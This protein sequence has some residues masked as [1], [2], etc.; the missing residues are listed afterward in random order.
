MLAFTLAGAGQGTSDGVGWHDGADAQEVSGGQAHRRARGS[1]KFA[2]DA[3]SRKSAPQGG[4]ARNPEGTPHGP[5]GGHAQAGSVLQGGGPK[6]GGPSGR[7]AP[8]LHVQPRNPG[9][10]ERAQDRQPS[11]AVARRPPARTQRHRRLTRQE[12][13]TRVDQANRVTGR[14]SLESEAVTLALQTLAGN[15]IPPIGR[16]VPYPGHR[17][18]Q[19]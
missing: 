5:A 9:S 17:E 18:K 16:E 2:P 14:R 7:S 10:R 3:A 6:D 4:K 19:T 11:S 15:R 8:R 12:L 13:A 1:P